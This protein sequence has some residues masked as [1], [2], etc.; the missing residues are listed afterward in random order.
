MRNGFIRN[1]DGDG[2]GGCMGRLPIVEGFA[3]EW[4][5]IPV[6]DND[7]WVVGLGSSDRRELSLCEN[8]GEIAAVEVGR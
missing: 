6:A 2:D 8:S 7:A 3:E 5:R 4:R 1:G